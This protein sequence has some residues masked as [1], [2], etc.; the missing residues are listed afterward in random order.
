VLDPLC[1]CALS[2]LVSSSSS[3]LSA[4]ALD[5]CEAPCHHAKQH[6]AQSRHARRFQP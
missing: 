3:L 4:S 5:S 1:C 2:F 6:A